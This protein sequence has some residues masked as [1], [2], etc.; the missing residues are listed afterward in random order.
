LKIRREKSQIMDSHP[1]FIF[2]RFLVYK[3]ECTHIVDNCSVHLGMTRF[4]CGSN[5]NHN[6][7]YRV[8]AHDWETDHPRVVFIDP[9]DLS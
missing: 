6:V 9:N 4:V 8:T 5:Y 3:M 2:L 1:F 7:C